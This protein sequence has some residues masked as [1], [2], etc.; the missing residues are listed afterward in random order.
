MKTT[1]L[2]FKATLLGSVTLA[3][4]LV[5]FTAPQA[6]AIT[7]TNCGTTAGP[8][9]VQLVDK[10]TNTSACAFSDENNDQVP[11]GGATFDVNKDGGIFG[12]GWSLIGKDAESLD[13][14][15]VGS[16]GSSTFGTFDISSVIGGSTLIDTDFMLVFKSGRSSAPTDGGFV[17]YLLSELTGSWTS[18]F[19]NPNNG[20]LKAMSH[21]SLYKRGK[22]CTKDCNPTDVPEPGLAIGL[23]AMAL[24]AIKARK[25]G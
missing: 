17:G 2:N 6:S 5:A 20:G 12:G 9:G 16:G 10:V 1:P 19:E 25:R 24:G 11:G 15:P 14:T 23:G 7:F 18:Q 4:G 8:S 13:F 21:I 3:A 22:E